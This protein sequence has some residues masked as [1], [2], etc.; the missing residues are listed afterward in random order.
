MKFDQG[1]AIF[2]TRGLLMHSYFRTSDNDTPIRDAE[3]NKV[4]RATSAMSTFINSYLVDTLQE[5]APKDII[6]VH[7]GGN[8]RRQDI[9]PEYKAQRKPLDEAVEAEINRLTNMAKNLLAGLGVTQVRVPNVEADD[10]IAWLTQRIEPFTIVETVDQDLIQ[11]ITDKIVVKIRGEVV[12]DMKGVPPHLVALQKSIVGDSS[13]NYSGVKGLGAKAWDKMVEEFGFD[14][15]EELDKIARTRNIKE[16]EEIATLEPEN[17]P[18][19]KIYNEY[20]TWLTM[21]QL[22]RVRPEWCEQTYRQKLTKPEWFKRIPDQNRVTE[23]LEMCGCMDLFTYFQPYMLQTVLITQD[24]LELLYETDFMDDLNESI[25]AFD[26]ETDDINE[27]TNYREV[28]KD[29]VDVLS[30][31]IVGASFTWGKN[32]QKTI[33]ICV[34]HKDTKNVSKEVIADILSEAENIVVQNSQFECTVTESEFGKEFTLENLHTPI[35]TAIMSSY[36]DE[37]TPAGL[38][39]NSA[40]WL[41]YKQAS[42]KETLG[43]KSKM[44]ELTGEETFGYGADDAVVTAHLWNLFDII[45]QL[46]ETRDFCYKHEF[47]TNRVF[48][49]AFIKGCRIDMKS[50][51][52]L[53]REDEGKLEEY[54]PRLHETLAENCKQEN[55]KATDLYMEDVREFEI[56]RMRYQFNQK[57]QGDVLKTLENEQKITAKLKIKEKDFLASTVYRPL[58]TKAI[59]YDFKPTKIQINAALMKLGVDDIE[60]MLQKTTVAG[61]SEW[62]NIL[63]SDENFP[64][65]AL[66]L[67]RLVQEAHPYFKTREGKEYDELAQFV[68]ELFPEKCK[69]QQTGDELNLGSPFQMTSLLYGK[70]ALPIRHRTKVTEGSTRQTLGFA[71]GPAANDKAMEIALAED[72]KDGGWKKDVIELIRDIK[73][74]NTRFSFYYNPYPLWVSPEDGKIHPQIRNCGTVTGRPSASSP[75]VLQVAKGPIRN[76]YLPLEDG[77]ILISPDFAGQELRILASESGDENM[78]GC[79]VGDDKRDLHSLT[80]SSIAPMSAKRGE[81]ELFSMME[82]DDGDQE[83][84]QFISWLDGEGGDEAKE[85]A[86]LMR[87]NDRAKCVSFCICYGGGAPTLSVNMLEPLEVAEEYL[88]KYL[89]TYPGV[90]L[91]QEESAKMGREWGYVKTAYGTRRHM[92]NTI[93]DT[94]NGRR[95]RMERQA[96]NARIQS[97]AANILKIVLTEC[98]ES[99]LL[100]DTGSTVLGPIYDE[101]LNSVPIKH[102]VEFCQR[103]QK[104]MDLTPPGHAVPMV[105]EFKLGFAWGN[106]VEIGVDTSEETILKAIKAAREIQNEWEKGNE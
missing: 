17:S 76:L 1:K 59:P 102:A 95:M 79:Y 2:D 57:I 93:L 77:H 44:S 19:R 49:D 103:L 9:L 4:T 7:E 55:Q 26:Y 21:Y 53:K 43:D 24:N 65:K 45:M 13:D 74:I 37:N 72:L 14:G 58:K 100:S 98:Y 25:V 64:S 90:S 96:G 28:N 56:E 29:F 32:L 51:E 27:F 61:V 20:R 89:E 35:D 73:E 54:W 18:L 50:L 34:N 97:C 16:L 60:Y 6:A 30:S 42:Y 91:F 47:V 36:V 71:G 15:M 31:R 92:T 88:N 86:K 33:Y 23:V 3:G 75:N 66:D 104:I 82:I 38:K 67:A 105:S 81:P 69:T 52:R 46:E 85:F 5:I 101:V 10:V 80:A 62:V 48:N 63:E 106:M 68:S 70:L 78:V 83:Y 12:Q 94:D 40:Q 87:G 11:L 22:A 84:S 8:A 41:N 39:Q 99:G